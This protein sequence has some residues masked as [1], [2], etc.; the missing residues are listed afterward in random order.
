VVRFSV[1]LLIVTLNLG[2]ASAQI[3]QKP[4]FSKSSTQQSY[5]V[6]AGFETVEASFKAEVSNVVQ[7]PLI[8]AKFTEEAFVANPTVYN[9]LL[10]HPDRTSLAWERS[11][12]P[13]LPIKDLGKAVFQ[14]K[15]ETGNEVNWQVVGTITDG[16]IWYATGKVKPGALSPTIPVKAVAVLKHPS[17]KIADGKIN[18]TPTINVYFQTESKAASAIMRMA[19]PAAPRMAEDGAEQLLFFFSGM[20]KYLEKHPDQ[21]PALLAPKKTTVNSAR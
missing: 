4:I 14:F 16:R 21:I 1:S 9:W 5:I 20:A 10:D 19:G 17:S 8:T 18:I 7:K 12:V 15:D 2:L 11:G 6:P 3:L 13:C